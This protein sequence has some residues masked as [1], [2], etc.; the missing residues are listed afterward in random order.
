MDNLKVKLEEFFQ[1]NV[2]K[3][4]DFENFPIFSNTMHTTKDLLPDWEESSG[5]AE[6]VIAVLE[7]KQESTP[8]ISIEEL[9]MMLDQFHAFKRGNQG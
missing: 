1:L 6:R 7:F 2:F 4:N 9:E 8:S 5:K 3:R